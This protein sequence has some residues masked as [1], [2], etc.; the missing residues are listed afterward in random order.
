VHHLLLRDSQIRFALFVHRRRFHQS[1][2]LNRCQSHGRTLNS[3]LHTGHHANERDQLF[4]GMLRSIFPVLWYSL[5]YFSRSIVR[6]PSPTLVIFRIFA[7]FPT[8][9]SFLCDV[10]E[11]R[12]HLERRMDHHW[13]PV[14]QVTS[15]QATVHGPLP[16]GIVGHP[17][18]RNHKIVA[19]KVTKL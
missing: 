7:F 15:S 2:P 10:R 11:K 8:R 3:K 4:R 17:Q 12:I 9:C 19:T 14:A 1:S 13:L 16:Y 6:N 5:W 18:C